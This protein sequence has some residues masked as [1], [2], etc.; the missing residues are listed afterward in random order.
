[1]E[2]E[3]LSQAIISLPN[4]TTTTVGDQITQVLDAVRQPA[5]EQRSPQGERVIEGKIIDVEG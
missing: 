1:M 5:L 4:G 3:F 2:K